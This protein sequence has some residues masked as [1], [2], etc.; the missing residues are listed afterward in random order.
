MTTTSDQ[1]YRRVGFSLVLIICVLCIYYMYRIRTNLA[2]NYAITQAANYSEFAPTHFR[3]YDKSTATTCNRL[4]VV[5]PFNWYLWAANGELYILNPESAVHCGNNTTPAVQVLKHRFVNVCLVMSFDSVVSA[6]TQKITPILI[7][8]DIDST[9]FTIIDAINLLMKSWLSFD[10][11]NTTPPSAVTYTDAPNTESQVS[12]EMIMST[13]APMIEKALTVGGGGGGA[14]SSNTSPRQIDIV[15]MTNRRANTTQTRSRR[16]RLKRSLDNEE[17]S[18]SSSPS[19]KMS[20][21]NVAQ[22]MNQTASSKS[23][24][25]LMALRPPVY[26][27]HEL[28]KIYA[29]TINNTKYNRPTSVSSPPVAT[30]W[31]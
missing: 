17:P 27:N 3:I 25:K 7:A 20:A 24:A 8:Y 31:S 18:E 1:W 15:D 2:V 14:T 6:Y 13:V 12:T 21:K 9:Q 4:I 28:Q 11:E 22:L 5:E 30:G 19:E 23:A 16:H 10:P 26:S 29:H